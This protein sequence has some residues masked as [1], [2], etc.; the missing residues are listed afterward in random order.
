VVAVIILA[1]G[2]LGAAAAFFL[3]GPAMAITNFQLTDQRSCGGSGSGNGNVAVTFDLVNT[4]GSGFATV[5][6]TVDGATDHTNV[7]HVQGDT[8]LPV[9]DSVFVKDCNAHTVAAQIQ[10]QTAGS[11]Y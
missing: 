6:Y 1:V 4:G 10:T 9:H 8:S 7:Y 3:R 2:G 5:A 11:G